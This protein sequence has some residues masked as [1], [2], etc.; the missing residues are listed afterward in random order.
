MLARCINQRSATGITKGRMY[1]VINDEDPT[2]VSI[3]NDNCTEAFYKRR[4]FHL[5][6]TD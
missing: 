6:V 3:K 1:N 4:R 2:Y 5:L